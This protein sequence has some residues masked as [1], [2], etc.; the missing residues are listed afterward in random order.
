MAVPTAHKEG[1]ALAHKWG[2]LSASLLE[3]VLVLM[4]GVARDKE[5]EMKTVQVKE[6]M[7]V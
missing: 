1:V 6:I 5:L 3:T 7:L 4:T 2:V